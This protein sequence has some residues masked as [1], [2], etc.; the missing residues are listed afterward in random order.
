MLSKNQ[1][2]F[3]CMFL[4]ICA[5]SLMDLV[6][7]WSAE[8]YPIGEVLFLRGYFVLRQIF[9]LIPKEKIHNFYKT[10]IVNLHFQRCLQA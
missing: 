9:F 7:K 8:T 6:V 10:Y 2:G 1:L 5:F 3:L 4:S